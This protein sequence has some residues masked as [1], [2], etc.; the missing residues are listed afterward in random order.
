MSRLNTTPNTWC[1]LHTKRC[2]VRSQIYTRPH[3]FAGLLFGDEDE[4]DDVL[5]L[6]DDLMGS[7]E[8]SGEEEDPEGEDAEDGENYSDFEEEEDEGVYFCVF[9][10]L[11]ASSVRYTSTTLGVDRSIGDRQVSYKLAFLK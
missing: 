5:G 3:H 10:R 2:A 11:W 7:G 4:D 6:V 8:E 1:D 9:F